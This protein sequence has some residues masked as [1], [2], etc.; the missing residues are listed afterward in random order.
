MTERAR[1]AGLWAQDAP[2]C[3]SPATQVAK[4]ALEE[5]AKVTAE[6]LAT[7][8]EHRDGIIAP[9]EKIVLDCLRALQA[10]PSVDRRYADVLMDMI[11]E[12]FLDTALEPRTSRRRVTALLRIATEGAHCG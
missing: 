5:Q 7:T 3:K 4:A 12:G 2:P 8:T 9:A 6:W 10:I 11:A 1:E